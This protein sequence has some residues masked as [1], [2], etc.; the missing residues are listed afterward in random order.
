MTLI[1]KV[2]IDDLA[3]TFLFCISK[4]FGITSGN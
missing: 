4:R 1:I 3:K 2:I